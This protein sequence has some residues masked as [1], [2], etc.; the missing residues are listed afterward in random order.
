M[1][2]AEENPEGIIDEQTAGWFRIHG[3]NIPE[4]WTIVPMKENNNWQNNSCDDQSR[5]SLLDWFA[6]QVHRLGPNRALELAESELQKLSLGVGI[7][8]GWTRSKLYE[9][10][11]SMFSTPTPPGCIVALLELDCFYKAEEDLRKRNDA[12][13]ARFEAMGGV[14]RS[15]VHETM[16]EGNA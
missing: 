9:A 10:C 1:R 12:L 4:R 11:K 13:R 3:V 2:L 14:V 16:L 15:D 6:V 7:L 5:R 8:D